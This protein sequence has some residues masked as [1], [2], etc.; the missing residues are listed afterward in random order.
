VN[1]IDEIRRS[2][3]EVN[4]M[5]TMR[6]E[7]SAHQKVRRFEILANIAPTMDEFDRGQHLIGKHKNSL[8]GEVRGLGGFAKGIKRRTEE[9]HRQIAMAAIYARFV[10]V[11]QVRGFADPP[12]DRRL[13][14][15][16]SERRIRALDLEGE[17]GIGAPENHF[18][19]FAEGAGA[20]A[21]LEGEVAENGRAPHWL[22]NPSVASRKGRGR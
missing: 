2:K 8:E 18:V 15:E 19:D 11:R 21:A 13:A 7:T 10:D 17:A 3:A 12:V 6:I 22:T 4:D 9:I 1:A 20:E 14:F 16:Q 5:E